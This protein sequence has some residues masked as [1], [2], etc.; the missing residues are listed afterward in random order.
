MKR[1]ASAAIFLPFF[2]VIVR[3]FGSV[4]VAITAAA[5]LL[6]LF[7]LYRL[8]EV[9]G[10]HC[11][12]VAGSLVT[13]LFLASFAVPGVSIHLP[14]LVGLFAIPLGSLRREGDLGEAF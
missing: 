1:V 8:A 10:R 14:I 11:F 7:E 2:Y 3:R 6:A 4:Y 5:A 9:R 12:R 13:L